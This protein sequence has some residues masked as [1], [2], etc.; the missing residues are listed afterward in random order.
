MIG[1]LQKAR[2]G[3]VSSAVLSRNAAVVLTFEKDALAEEQ[4]YL[5]V[6]DL[7]GNKVHGRVYGAKV[8]EGKA[9]TALLFDGAD[10]YVSLGNP[11]ALQ[12]TGSQTIMMWIRPDRLGAR[13]NPYAK[14]YGGEGTLTLEPDGRLHYYFGAAGTNG[15]PYQTCEMPG[16]QAGRWSHVAVVRDLDARKVRLYLNGVKQ[17]EYP[18]TTSVR[19]SSRNAYLGRG[20]TEYFAGTIDEFAL[21]ARALSEKEVRL[22]IALG[23]E[24]RPLK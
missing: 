13:R 8:V 23:L 4:G 10:D 5:V 17:T 21:F 2:F 3:E 24:G 6:K 15:P 19:A 7:S 1:E 16:V 20:Y 22:L 11:A 12:I 9:G 14:A 18:V